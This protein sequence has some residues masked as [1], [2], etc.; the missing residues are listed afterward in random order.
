MKAQVEKE[1]L[2]DFIIEYNKELWKA[3]TYLQ[4]F[5]FSEFV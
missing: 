2:K 5:I 1:K 4:N 3:L